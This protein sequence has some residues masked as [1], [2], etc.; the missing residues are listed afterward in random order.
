MY[1]TKA[2]H[3]VCI[4]RKLFLNP[5]SYLSGAAGVLVGHPFDTVKVGVFFHPPHYLL[6]L[7][8]D[9]IQDFVVKMLCVRPL[10]WQ[11]E[12]ESR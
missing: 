10:C 11:P 5:A 3:S 8:N 12:F 4:F 6:M 1:L 7:G 2:C 9:M